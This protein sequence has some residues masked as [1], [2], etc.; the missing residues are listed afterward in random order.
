MKFFNH[1]AWYFSGAFILALIGVAQLASDT[2]SAFE[3]F[4]WLAGSGFLIY[5]GYKKYLV[6]KVDKRLRTKTLKKLLI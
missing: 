6:Y 2:H 4:L 5:W 3:A 1:P